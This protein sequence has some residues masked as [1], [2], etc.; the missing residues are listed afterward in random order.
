VDGQSVA[1]IALIRRVHE[2]TVAAWGR[3]CCGDGITGV[4]RP[5]PRGR[6]PQLTPTPKAARATRRDEGPVKAG[7]SGA[8]W[9]S[10]MIQPVIY[11]RLGLFSTVFS[12]AQRLKNRGFR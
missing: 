11:A 7:F 1:P 2:Q 8:C 4:P 3:V 6:P 9:R 5:K 12:I 10:P